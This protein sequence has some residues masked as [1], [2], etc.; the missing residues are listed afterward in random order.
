MYAFNLVL[1][2]FG[3]KVKHKDAK[4][5]D[6]TSRLLISLFSWSE[7]LRHTL[8]IYYCFPMRIELIRMKISKNPKNILKSFP[9]LLRYRS[10]SRWAPSKPTAVT[11]FLCSVTKNFPSNFWGILMVRNLNI[12][13]I[14]KNNVTRVRRIS[15]QMTTKNHYGRF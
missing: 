8:V 3:S 2:S 11:S 6:V 5:K 10:F 14:I 7:V 1:F 15:S 12:I 13:I 9:Y 4:R